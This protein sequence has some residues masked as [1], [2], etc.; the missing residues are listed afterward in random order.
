MI[1]NI[2]CEAR[3]RKH[4]ISVTNFVALAGW[5]GND[6]HAAAYAV[7]CVT[8]LGFAALILVV[9]LAFIN[10]GETIKTPEEYTKELGIDTLAKIVDKLFDDT[11]IYSIQTG[12]R[13]GEVCLRCHR[14]DP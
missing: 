2:F 13:I 8:G 4:I 12:A 11:E 6:G 10:Q 14:I 9:V 3:L 7:Y 5:T 1:L